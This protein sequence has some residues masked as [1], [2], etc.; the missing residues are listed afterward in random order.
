MDATEF[1]DAV[2]TKRAELIQENQVIRTLREM[3]NNT[4]VAKKKPNSVLGL[5]T[6]NED[7]DLILSA[8][9]GTAFGDIESYLEE[10]EPEPN[11][12]KEVAFELAEALG[13]K[14]ILEGVDF[15]L[16]D[17]NFLDGVD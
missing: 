3:A 11:P 7:A 14:V 5:L 16:V 9:E 4:Y 6:T 2:E 17:A 12:V 1:N 10:Q 13:V 15:G 8:G